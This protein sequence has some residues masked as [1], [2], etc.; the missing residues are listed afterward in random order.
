[1]SN[2]RIWDGMDEDIEYIEKKLK[3]E[4]LERIAN[5]KYNYKN[6]AGRTEFSKTTDNGTWSRNGEDPRD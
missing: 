5:K 4:D 1:M 2:P 6:N 3:P